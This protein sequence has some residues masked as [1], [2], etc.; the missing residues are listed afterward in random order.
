MDPGV[1]TLFP[2]AVGPAKPL[3]IRHCRLQLLALERC[4]PSANFLEKMKINLFSV[5]YELT[6]LLSPELNAANSGNRR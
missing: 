6:P 1:P 3:A 4:K 2:V 5:D